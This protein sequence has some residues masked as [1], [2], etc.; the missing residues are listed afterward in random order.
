MAAGW[1]YSLERHKRAWRWL[2]AQDPDVALLQEVIPPSWAQDHWP[3]LIFE[4]TY[5]SKR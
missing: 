2:E 1:G 4:R 5:P 3:S